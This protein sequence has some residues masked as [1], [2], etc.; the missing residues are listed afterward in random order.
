M[1]SL[2]SIDINSS[3]IDNLQ[4]V[5]AIHVKTNT[6][7]KILEIRAVE[8]HYFLRRDCTLMY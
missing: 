3:S 8:D 4:R 5:L 6:G 1:L 7:N 2:Q